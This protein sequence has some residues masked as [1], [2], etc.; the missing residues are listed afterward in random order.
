MELEMVVARRTEMIDDPD[1]V[2][3]LI[4]LPNENC[5]LEAIVERT[6]PLGVAPIGTKVKVA[7]NVVT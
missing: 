7:L 2:E 4:I 6:S 1:A 3:V 5:R